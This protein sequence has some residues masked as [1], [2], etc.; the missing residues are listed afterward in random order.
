MLS[1][2]QNIHGGR[3]KTVRVVGAVYFAV[4]TGPVTEGKLSATMNVVTDWGG[5]IPAKG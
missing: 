1:L 4:G 2:V 3:G 5:G